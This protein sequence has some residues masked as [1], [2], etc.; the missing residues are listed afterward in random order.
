MSSPDTIFAALG[1]PTRM[2]LVT[3]L[4]DGQARSIAQLTRAHSLTRQGITKHLR[5][6]EDAGLVRSRKVGRE[7]VFEFEPAP[8]QQARS[9]IEEV[10]A[11]WDDALER[12]RKMVDT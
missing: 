11:K 2:A 4:G 3:R 9:Y 8:M 1:D 10:C 5:V 12:L 7:N 6:L